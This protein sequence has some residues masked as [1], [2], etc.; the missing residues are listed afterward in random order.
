MIDP[1]IV[2]EVA[3]FSHML[4]VGCQLLLEQKLFQALPEKNRFVQASTASVL[5]EQLKETLAY[6]FANSES[7]SVVNIAYEWVKAVA[8]SRQP[9]FKA[10]K[11]ASFLD[12]VRERMEWLL[13]VELAGASGSAGPVVHSGRTAVEVLF[14]TLLKDIDDGK[15]LNLGEL[16]VFDTFAWLLTDAQRLQHKEWIGMVFKAA[17]SSVAPSSGSQAKSAAKAPA[18]GTTAVKREAQESTMGLFKKRK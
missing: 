15:A 16:K 7:Q 6:K 17:G 13:R 9:S 4:E 14:T 18:K 8:N 2:V 10:I 5:I 1:S 11:P 12:Q 3:W